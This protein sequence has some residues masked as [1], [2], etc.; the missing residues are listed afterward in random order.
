MNQPKI[1]KEN[2]REFLKCSKCK[3]ESIELVGITVKK[4]NEYNSGRFKWVC[5]DCQASLIELLA[6]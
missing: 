5:R 6:V 3:N 2:G 1:H 4:P